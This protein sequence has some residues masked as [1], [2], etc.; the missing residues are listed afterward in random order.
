MPRPDRGPCRGRRAGD[1]DSAR[2]PPGR[3]RRP[4]AGVGIIA[5]AT[6]TARSLRVGDRHL[7]SGRVLPVRVG[8]AAD[9]ADRAKHRDGQFA[10]VI[11]QLISHRW[12]NNIDSRPHGPSRA[13]DRSPAA[14]R[15]AALLV[16]P[17]STTA[18]WPSAAESSPGAAAAHASGP[19]GRA[20]RLSNSRRT[21]RKGS[22]ARSSTPWR[23]RSHGRGRP[24]RT[25]RLD[26]ERPAEATPRDEAAERPGRQAPRPRRRMAYRPAGL[27]RR[28]IVVA[29]AEVAAIDQAA[30]ADRR[31]AVR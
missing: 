17:R 27:G 29:V 16:R 15:V 26:A 3:P 18:N 24:R 8:I 11:D 30:D 19:D 1:A 7:G 9:K 5:N 22:P 28:G 20:S 13:Q 31:T 21:R 10:P 12:S 23:H 14:P 2:R 25:H 4:V 6:S